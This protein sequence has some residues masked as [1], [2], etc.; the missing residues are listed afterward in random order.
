MDSGAFDYEKLWLTSA[1]RGVAMMNMTVEAGMQGYHS[2]ELG[3]IIPE[4]FRVARELLD[5][6]DDP[7][8]GRVCEELQCEIPEWAKDE[9]KRMAEYSG[10]TMYKKYRIHEGVK[11]MDQDNLA[12]MYLNNTWRANLSIV[13]ADGLPS[14]AKGGNVLRASTTLKLSMRLPPSV[15]PHKACEDMKKKLS[16]DVPYNCKVTFPGGTHAG[17]GWCQKD[18]AEWLKAAIL[19]SGKDFYDG[20]DGSSYGMGGSIPL[21]SELEKMYPD[22]QILGLGLIGPKSNAHAPNECI[23]LDY[24]KKLTCALSHMIAAVGTQ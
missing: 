20:K 10:D 16:T 24:A 19:E 22:A 8:T 5:R 2:G 17:Q 1:L 13:A 4:T 18:P 7:K 3:G 12:E 23:N 15:D 14:T 11:C 6:I 9:A 21:L